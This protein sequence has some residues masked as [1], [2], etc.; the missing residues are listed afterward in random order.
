MR[1]V[2]VRQTSAA[3]VETL[4]DVA[5]DLEHAAENISGIASTTV[6]TKGGFGVGTR[7]RET[8]R[9]LGRDASEEME[10]TAVE[11]GRSYTAE[12]SSSGMHYVTVWDF[13]PADE[14][15]EVVMRFSGTPVSRLSKV[16]SPM[17]SAMSS[18]MEK[19]MRQDMADLAA[20][21]ANRG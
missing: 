19:M 15:S 6:L 18:S 20:A 14:G 3:S 7:W 8:R 17:M 10:I 16:V 11:P 5:T 13:H 9:M 2:T 1:T 12:A 4:W 21:A